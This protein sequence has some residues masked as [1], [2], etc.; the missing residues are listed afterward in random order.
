MSI[1]LQHLRE[2]AG[3]LSSFIGL[4]GEITVETT[5]FRLQVHD[6]TTPGGHPAARLADMPSVSALGAVATGAGGSA[7]SIGT[8][9]E[10]VTLSGGA[11]TSTVQ[12]P[13][14]AIVFA[15]ST[16]VV[17]AIA[18]AT[19]FK[20]DATVAAGGGAGSSGGQFGSGLGTSV[21]STNV[22]VIGPTAWYAPSTITITATGGG[23]TAGQ[24]RIAV[25]YMVCAAP[26]S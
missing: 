3:F 25:Q 5:N 17:A 4:P 15:V 22:G 14:R 6:G 8:L 20:V 13:A 7:V 18:G 1:R 24:V 23:F 2:A 11:A 9:E 10:L 19:S 21:G 26:T 16:R 12:I